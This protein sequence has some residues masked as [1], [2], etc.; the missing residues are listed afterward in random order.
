MKSIA[1]LIA[2]A[3]V[4]VLFFGDYHLDTPST[5]VGFCQGQAGAGG[6]S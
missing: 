1:T 2:G 4:Y 6:A 5:I 3:I